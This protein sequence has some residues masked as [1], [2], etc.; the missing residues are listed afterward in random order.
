MSN[1]G[2]TVIEALFVIALGTLIMA[3]AVP[4]FVEILAKSRHGSAVRRLVTDV[5]EARSQAITTGWEYRVIGY[6]AGASSSRHNQYRVLARRSTAVDWPDEDVE[7][8][9][10]ETQIAGRWVDLASDY[11]G[12]GVDASATR[13]EVTFDSRGTAPDAED[14]FNPLRLVADDGLSSSLTVSVVGGIRVE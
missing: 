12:V 6:D 7:P 4:S 9:A 11:P 1:R 10:S 13:F 14:A 3:L 2:F 5:R 8:F